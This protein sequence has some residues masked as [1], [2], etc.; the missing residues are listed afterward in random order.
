MS[1]VCQKLGLFSDMFDVKK[2]KQD[3]SCLALV[4]VCCCSLYGLEPQV[5]WERDRRDKVA[6][7]AQSLSRLSRDVD[8]I[9]MQQLSRHL[10]C[11]LFPVEASL[12]FSLTSRRS[13]PRMGCIVISFEGCTARFRSRS[14]CSSET[15]YSHAEACLH[16]RQNRQAAS[17]TCEML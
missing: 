9:H 7:V 4:A 15:L 10:I 1:R 6:H 12:I 8:N 2:E 11:K 16:T 5:K 14:S 13:V 17:H 3:I